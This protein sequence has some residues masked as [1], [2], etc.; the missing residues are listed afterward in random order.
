MTVWKHK[1]ISSESPDRQT[2]IELHIIIS[3]QGT[4]ILWITPRIRAIIEAAP[5]ASQRNDSFALGPLT[6][7]WA[8]A[9]CIRDTYLGLDK[10]II[11]M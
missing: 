3:G 10:S 1:S 7:A 4:E 6:E 5:D 2:D 11:Y 8:I 9:G